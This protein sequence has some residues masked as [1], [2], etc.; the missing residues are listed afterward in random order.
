MIHGG[1]T[2]VSTLEG[3]QIT[4]APNAIHVRQEYEVNPAE[5]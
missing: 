1:K 5:V 3:E 2:S 4:S